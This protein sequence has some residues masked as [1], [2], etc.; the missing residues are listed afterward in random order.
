M[1]RYVAVMW[2][3]ERQAICQAFA[4]AEL[5]HQARVKGLESRIEQPLERIDVLTE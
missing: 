5:A 1:T 2:K 3:T 4:E